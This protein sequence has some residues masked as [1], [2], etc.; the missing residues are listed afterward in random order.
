MFTLMIN[1]IFNR[2]KILKLKIIEKYKNDP[3]KIGKYTRKF[4]DILENKLLQ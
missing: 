4:G 2:A 3:D 1:H